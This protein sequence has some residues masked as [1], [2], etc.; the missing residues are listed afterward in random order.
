MRRVAV[1]GCSDS[2]VRLWDTR[3]GAK[4]GKLKAHHDIVRCVR[5]MGDIGSLT[6]L[7]AASDGVVCLW[8]ARMLSHALTSTHPCH[9]DSIWALALLPHSSTSSPRIITGSRSGCIS[10]SDLATGSCTPLARCPFPVRKLLP[11]P[12]SAAAGCVY[13]A[14]D[15]TS[16][17]ALDYSAALTDSEV[18][19]GLGGE[20][21]V[22]GGGLEGLGA[23]ALMSDRMRAVCETTSGDVVMCSVLTGGILQRWAKVR[24]RAE[25]DP[26]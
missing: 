26:P 13:V 14:A 1:T 24:R 17:Y 23:C 4:V 12:H 6:L 7:S 10:L 20:A 21:V 15:C 25:T 3:S 2:A 22:C 8:D 16:L 18:C 11:V 19:C 9:D 5:V